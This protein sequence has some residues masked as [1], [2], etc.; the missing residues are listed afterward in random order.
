MGCAGET[1]IGG[2]YHNSISSPPRTRY[3]TRSDTSAKSCCSLWRR[4]SPESAPSVWVKWRTYCWCWWWWSNQ[5][6]QY[7]GETSCS[8]ERWWWSGWTLSWPPQQ[9]LAPLF[10]LQWTR[11]LLFLLE[12]GTICLSQ[13]ELGKIKILKKHANVP[14]PVALIKSLSK[15]AQY[16]T[17]EF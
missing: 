1:N 13:E 17:A 7:W 12:F 9:S 11:L 16:H 15:V 4:E 2:F 10:N 6:R 8:C 5:Q 3:F 14:I